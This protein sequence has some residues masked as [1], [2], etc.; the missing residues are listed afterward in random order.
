MRSLILAA[1]A[2]VTLVSHSQAAI[3]TV[4]AT[5]HISSASLT[6]NSQFAGELPGYVGNS[7]TAQFVIDTLLGSP[8]NAPVYV[9]IGG[10]GA[11]SPVLSATV[12][13]G[14][15]FFSF[16]PTFG[17]AMNVDFGGFKSL[18]YSAESPSAY[19]QQPDNTPFN[20]M[21]FNLSSTTDFPALWDQKFDALPSDLVSSLFMFQT[22][23]TK[24][25]RSPDTSAFYGSMETFKIEIA[26]AVPEPSTWAML[27]LGLAGVGFMACRRSRRDQDLALASAK[28]E[29]RSAS[30]PT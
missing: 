9:G 3:L 25:G 7:F 14:G 2:A 10:S 16:V 8:T 26:E 1:L 22:G 13:I 20:W 23:A 12:G 24:F 21:Q 11:N 19:S 27:I 30:C 15:S 29:K 5:G 6:V 17:Q 4:T 28:A 18:N